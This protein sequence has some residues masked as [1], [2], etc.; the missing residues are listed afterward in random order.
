[1]DLDLVSGHPEPLQGPLDLTQLEQISMK[2]DGLA[3]DHSLRS[4]SAGHAPLPK[5]APCDLDLQLMDTSLSA[6]LWA[7]TPAE[8][9]GQMAYA[10]P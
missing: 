7:G 2:D 3:F 4:S 9:G 10:L 1:M 5:V 6:G 8:N